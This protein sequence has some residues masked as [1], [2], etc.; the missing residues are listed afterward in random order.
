MHCH[1]IMQIARPKIGHTLL[2]LSW[3]YVFALFSLFWCSVDALLTLC[4]HSVDT[5]LMLC[6]CCVDGLLML[7]WRS[8]DA[9]LMLCWG[10]VEALLRLSWCSVDALLKVIFRTKLGY[11]H[12]D[13]WQD[14]QPMDRLWIHVLTP[15]WDYQ[16]CKARNHW[17]SFDDHFRLWQWMCCSAFVAITQAYTFRLEGSDNEIL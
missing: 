4:G 6:W 9:L 15:P 1:W 7:C 13:F 3:R 17:C 12:N 11:S 16:S 10:S 5:L 8:V 14:R 2:M